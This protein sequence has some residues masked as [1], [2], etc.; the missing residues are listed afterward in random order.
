M[1]CFVD[2]WYYHSHSTGR[3]GAGNLAESTIPGI[4]HHSRHATVP[5][6]TGRGGAGNIRNYSQSRSPGPVAMH[7]TG[8]GGADNIVVGDA[9]VTDNLDYEERKQHHHAQG[10]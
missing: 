5:E 8:R 7:S 6:S 10:M 9:T 2:C 1:D 3:G 4:E